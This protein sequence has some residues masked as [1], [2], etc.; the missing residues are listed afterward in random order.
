MTDSTTQGFTVRPHGHGEERPSTRSEKQHLSVTNKAWIFMVL[1]TY[2][3]SYYV[4]KHL[5]ICTLENY[6]SYRCSLESSLFPCAHH[7]GNCPVSHSVQPRPI[8]R[9]KYHGYQGQGLQQAARAHKQLQ[10]DV[11]RRL[12]PQM[13][14]N[15]LVE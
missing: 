8:R 7:P 1:I 9:K 6:S 14:R 11:Q 15:L 12:S 10:I 13:S 2:I 4:D 3:H 5:Y